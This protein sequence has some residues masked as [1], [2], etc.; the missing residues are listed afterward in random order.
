MR[1]FGD[2][3]YATIEQSHHLPFQ[4]LQKLELVLSR[5]EQT[6][7]LEKRRNQLSHLEEADRDLSKPS[8][9]L[10]AKLDEI[11]AQLKTLQTGTTSAANGQDEIL[12][13]SHSLGETSRGPQESGRG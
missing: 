5:L 12:L 3:G 4:T 13:S 2:I 10:E 7:G 11:L 9:H 8:V 1:S 6:A